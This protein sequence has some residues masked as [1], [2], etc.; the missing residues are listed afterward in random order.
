MRPLKNGDTHSMGMRRVLVELSRAGLPR[1]YAPKIFAKL[2]EY[3][4]NITGYN[5]DE[6]MNK[7]FAD[8]AT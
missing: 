1:G 8:S 4:K 7:R 5:V 6:G 2:L 3:S